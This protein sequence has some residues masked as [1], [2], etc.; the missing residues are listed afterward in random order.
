MDHT[1]D[2]LINSSVAPVIVAFVEEL[3]WQIMVE[4]YGPRMGEYARML[5]DELVPHLQAKYRTQRG[6]DAT[7]IMG[8]GGGGQVAVYTALSHPEV[9]GKVAVRSLRLLS[10]A[11][12]HVLSLVRGPKQPVQF[13][14]GWDRYDARTIEYIDMDIPRD[15]RDLA[16]LLEEKGY[17]WTGGETVEGAA[18]WGSR[19]D[20]I[21]KAFF[22]LRPGN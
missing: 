15:S 8:A 21:L 7:A 1:L 9:F 11:G 6:S 10:P 3:S 2:N 20:R 19:T 18:A 12:D 17:V 4:E 16:D 14:V 13:H 22:P 5:G